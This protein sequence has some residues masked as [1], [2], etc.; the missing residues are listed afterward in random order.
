MQL[1]IPA[2]SPSEFVHGHFHAVV[3]GPAGVHTHQ[4]QR[5]VLGISA[6]RTGVDG[7]H[8]TLF[9]VS[10]AEQSLQF[11]AIEFRAQLGQPGLGFPEHVVVR[12]EGVELNRRVCVVDSAF[13]LIQLLQLSLHLIEAAHLLLGVLLVVPEVRLGGEL[14]E[15]L[16]PGFQCRNVKD[17][18]GHCPGGQ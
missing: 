10:T 5:P 9:V 13:P 8:G 7:E 14:F 6:A 12:L 11:P 3:F 15:V 4:H 17:S 2:S 16:L 18:P 1:L